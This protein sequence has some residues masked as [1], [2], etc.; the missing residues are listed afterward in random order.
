MVFCLKDSYIMIWCNPSP[1][2][3]FVHSTT[4]NDRV[5]NWSQEIHAI[6]SHRFEHTKA[7]DS[8]LE[9]SLSGLK[10]LSLYE[11]NALKKEQDEY[12]KSIFNSEPEAVCSIDSNQKVNQEFEIQSIRY[13][14]NS[15]HDNDL[16]QSDTTVKP[17]I[18]DPPQCKLDLD[19]VKQFQGQ[20]PHLSKIII[21]CTFHSHHDKTPFYLAGNRV[22]YRKVRDRSNIFHIIMIPQKVQTYILYECQNALGHKGSTRLYSFIKWF[23]LE[24]IVSGL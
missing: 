22:V 6:K 2:Q 21:K 11:T 9:D 13:H 23:L 18:Q 1:L 17:Q 8:N 20:D 19:E 4:K 3:R 7:K 16:L 14:F 15:K 5:N 24:K 10:T 12:G